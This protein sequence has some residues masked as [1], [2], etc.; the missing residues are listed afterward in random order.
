MIVP[1]GP[2][3]VDLLGLSMTDERVGLALQSLGVAVP[4]VTPYEELDVTMESLGVDIRFEPPVQLRDPFGVPDD[5]L[6]MS[7]LF[8]H[9]TQSSSSPYRG[10][11]PYGLSLEQTRPAVNETLDPRVGRHERGGNMWEFD[12]REVRVDFTDGEQHIKLLT[13]GLLRSGKRPDRSL[14]RPH[15]SAATAALIRRVDAEQ[16]W[17]R[18]DANAWPVPS[19][20]APPERAVLQ[21]HAGDPL[22]EDWLTV[23]DDP[24]IAREYLRMPWRAATARF[25]R[26]VHW[27]GELPDSCLIGYWNAGNDTFA[28]APLLHIDSEASCSLVGLTFADFFDTGDG[29]N[30]ELAAFLARTALPAP[31]PRTERAQALRA[32]PDPDHVYN[33][34][35]AM[36]PSPDPVADGP[37]SP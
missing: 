30:P 26:D 32:L 37:R 1:S 31:T 25:F 21:R 19:A 7:M 36:D 6:V 13:V 15:R 17:R 22:L 12:R 5:G 9:G 29:E 14:L 10:E 18:W 4:E 20:D 2:R 34:M 28:G 8:F 33:A 16:D 27:I 23:T 3:L 11:L 35:L 24:P